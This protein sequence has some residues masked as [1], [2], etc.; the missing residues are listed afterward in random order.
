[1]MGSRQAYLHELQITS[2]RVLLRMKI[3]SKA[4]ERWR[5]DKK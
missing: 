3:R 4:W 5:C 2:M 1:M